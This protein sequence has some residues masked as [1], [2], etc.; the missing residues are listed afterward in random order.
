MNTNPYISIPNT[1]SKSVQSLLAPYRT[2]IIFPTGEVGTFGRA[3]LHATQWVHVFGDLGEGKPCIEV[4]DYV[5]TACK[6]VFLTGGEHFTTHPVPS[7]FQVSHYL[8]N[9]LKTVFSRGALKIGA[10]A[11]IH[12]RVTIR[13]GVTI[14]EGAIVGAGSVVTKDVPPFA[15]VAGNPAVILRYRI[16]ERQ[17][18]ILQKMRWWEWKEIYIASYLA[19]IQRGEEVEVTPDMIEPKDNYFVM[20]AS[21][22]ETEGYILKLKS[23][24]MQGKEIPKEKFTGK[25]E[26]WRQQFSKKPG[27]EIILVND[28]F[29]E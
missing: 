9:T 28:A 24:V 16:P 26:Y 10:G 4:G 8:K 12:S 29:D 1:G 11:V 17:Q 3:A 2:K 6:G 23:A 7:C 25:M 18:E 19:A 13:S 27:E 15:I 5:E 22:A 21:F 20:Q 14:G